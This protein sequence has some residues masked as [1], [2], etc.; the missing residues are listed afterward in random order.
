MAGHKGKGGANSAH[1]PFWA[2]APKGADALCPHHLHILP[3]CYITLC[4]I[5]LHHL[6]RPPPPPPAQS[7]LPHPATHNGRMC[8]W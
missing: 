5:T 3:L 1:H 7:E 4:H 6:C 8:R 2:L